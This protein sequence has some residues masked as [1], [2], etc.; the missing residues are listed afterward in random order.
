MCRIWLVVV[1]MLQ[2][3]VAGA[4]A[5]FESLVA[6]AE[7]ARDRLHKTMALISQVHLYAYNPARPRR[8]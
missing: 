8:T 3:N 6:E 4:A 7:E 1:Q 2:G 5:Q